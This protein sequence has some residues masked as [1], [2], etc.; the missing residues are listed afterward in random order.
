MKYSLEIRSVTVIESD[1]VEL[2]GKTID[3]VL[4]FEKHVDDSC[5]TAHNKLIASRRTK[6][7]LTL[8]KLLGNVFI[9]SQIK[10]APLILMFCHKITY[11]KMQKIYHKTLKNIYRSDTSYNHL[12]QL[13]NSVSHPH[14]RFFMEIYKNTGSLNPQFIWS[15]FKYREVPYNLKQVPVLFILPE[16]V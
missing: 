9:D 12:L 2:L 6:K 14:L 13:S 10:Y 1:E 4:N 7:Y 16:K 5:R 11:L 3:K 15:Y 8:R